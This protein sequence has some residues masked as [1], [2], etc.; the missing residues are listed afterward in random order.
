MKT[1]S[2]LALLA[3]LAGA[4]LWMAAERGAGFD[5]VVS[6]VTARPM[7]DGA[8]AV[9]MGFENAGTPDRLIGVASDAGTATLYS[10]A[11]N[12][13]P[14]VPAGT[15]ALA[16]DAAHVRIE[17][18]SDLPEDGTLLPLTLRFAEAG[19]IAVKARLVAASDMMDH[20]AMDHS[21]M[22]HATMEHGMTENDGVLGTGAAYP[23][24]EG[25]P[26]PGLT[27]TAAPEGDGWRIRLA[28]ENF[29][30]AED[31]TDGAHV[32]GTGHGHLYV[33]GI[34][35]GRVYSDTAFVGALPPGRHEVRVT[36][37]TNDHRAYV[38]G[39]QPVTATAM[40]SVD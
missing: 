8:L 40:I 32:P 30:F 35:I 16:L 15:S 1:L 37:N 28:T 18:Q 36:L 11:A 24:P 19:E 7:A 9:T 12:P 5:L 2:L 31:L 13:D 14:P 26:A 21:T 20:G 10:P 17:L 33:G 22:D 3:L 27:L 25:E 29:R 6:D 23:V 34:K 4:A 38:A 39:G